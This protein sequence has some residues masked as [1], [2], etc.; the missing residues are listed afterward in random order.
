MPRSQ[1]AS[2]S[3]GRCLRES[4]GCCDLLGEFRNIDFR[5][6]KQIR[7][8]D[9][10]GAALHY[11]SAHFDFFLIAA[12]RRSEE[13]FG[14]GS[15]I[16]VFIPNESEYPSRRQTVTNMTLRKTGRLCQILRGAAW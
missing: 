11:R 5:T 16:E 3:F 6:L 14:T 9:P 12:N 2:A 13:A 7:R 15:E 1:N 4:A 10:D 8:D